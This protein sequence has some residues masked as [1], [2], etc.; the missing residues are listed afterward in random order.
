M[1]DPIIATLFVVGSGE[2]YIEAY[3]AKSLW[4]TDD[5]ILLRG[6]TAG[7]GHATGTLTFAPQALLT[8]AAYAPPCG[9]KRP[10]VARPYGAI[11]QAGWFHALEGELTRTGDAPPCQ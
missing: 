2:D 7:A 1:A 8:Q 11:R 3:R 9:A 5:R 6:R 10:Y 4:W